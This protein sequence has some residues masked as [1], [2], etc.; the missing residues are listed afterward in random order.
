MKG[1]RVGKG[2]GTGG[3]VYSNKNGKTKTEIALGRVKC[4]YAFG[5]ALWLTIGDFNAIL[6]GSEK[7]GGQVRRRRCSLFGKEVTNDE[8]KPVLFDMTPL[9]APRSDGFQAMFF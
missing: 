9:K 4:Y 1:I 2:C 6:F 8:I 3:K 5:G 7:R